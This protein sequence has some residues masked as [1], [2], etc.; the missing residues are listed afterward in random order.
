MPATAVVQQTTRVTTG[1]QDFTSSGFGTP[2][3]AIFLVSAGTA[4]G[5]AVDHALCGIGVTDGTRQWS[6]AFRDHDAQTTTVCHTRGNATDCFQMVNEAGTVILK[7]QFS[8]WI[9]DGIRVNVSTTN[10]TAYYVT[11]ILLGGSDITGVYCNTAIG[12]ATADSSTTVNTV[13]FT[14][15]WMLGVGKHSG[16]AWD[17][18]SDGTLM[19]SIGLCV[20]DGSATQMNQ[21][22]LD[23]GGQTTTNVRSRLSLSRF[24]RDLNGTAEIEIQNFTS[25]GFDATTRVA[26]EAIHFGYLCVAQ[27]KQAKLMQFD[28]P[29]A[30]G[31]ADVSGIGFRPQAAFILP[32]GVTATNSTVTDGNAEVG[33]IGFCNETAAGCIS[34]TS[35]DG[36]TTTNVECLTSSNPINLRKD[37]ALFMRASTP[38]FGSGTLTL[39]Y[40]TTSGTARKFVGLFLEAA[41]AAS[42]LFGKLLGRL[43][44][45]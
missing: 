15:S 34:Y 23:V 30:T 18:T 29:T 26:S 19:V 6:L 25:S 7:A 33:G 13:G 16:N 9:T 20:N 27:T 5:T 37:A 42:L 2:L 4:L 28:T 3:G 35:D 39:N 14:T 32:S 31:N 10:G 1:T 36:V 44:R 12:N 38:V 24:L 22:F 43:G 41:G 45:V 17:D 11:C 8:A 21:A 40:D